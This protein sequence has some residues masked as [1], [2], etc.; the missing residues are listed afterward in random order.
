[1]PTE[2][3][4][5]DK[6]RPHL[7]K[8]QIRVGLDNC[9]PSLAFWATDSAKMRQSGIF[10][11]L[12][13]VG[14]VVVKLAIGRDVVAVDTGRSNGLLFTTPSAEVYGLAVLSVLDNGH[15]VLAVGAEGRGRVRHTCKSILEKS[16]LRMLNLQHEVS[17]F[18]NFLNLHGVVTH[19]VVTK[20]KVA[21]FLQYL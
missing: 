18:L 8:P 19:G 11:V 7:G 16:E 12:A 1:M 15:Q 17:F 6:P 13:P 21:M 3:T 20:N 2:W 9:L 5:A 14:P 4:F 10:G